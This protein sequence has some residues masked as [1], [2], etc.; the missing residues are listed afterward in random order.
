[1]A[2]RASRDT[3]LARAPSSYRRGTVVT[4]SPPTSEHEDSSV[5]YSRSW[6]HL[7]EVAG[8]RGQFADAWSR[9][10][11]A[12]PYD[13]SLNTD[14]DGNGTISVWVTWTDDQATELNG[15]VIN[16]AAQL[17]SA[18]DESVRTTAGL[19]TGRGS[20]EQP[21]TLSFPICTTEEEFHA[22]LDLDALR[23]LRPDQVRLVRSLQPI[24]QEQPVHPG[25]Q[26]M[27]NALMLLRNLTS[28][29]CGQTP[30]PPR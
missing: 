23:W 3:S 5:S 9:L 7:K 29:G 19:L 2:H 17:Q 21:D 11:D 10:L 14:L 30:S 13:I 18:L 15:L 12:E 22:A 27:R 6:R 20:D 25:L 16:L 24:A 8:L 4:T 28:A 26:I 1:M